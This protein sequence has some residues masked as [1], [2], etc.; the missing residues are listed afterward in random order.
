MRLLY[1]R[2]RPT[3]PNYCAALKTDDLTKSWAELVERPAVETGRAAPRL[4]VMASAYRE[5]Y[6]PLLQYLRR[7]A[8][9]YQDRTIAVTVP[10]IVERRW[11]NFFFRHRTTL[12]KGLLLLRG[13]PRIVI[14]TTPWYPRDALRSQD[15]LGSC[16]AVESGARHPPLQQAA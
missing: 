16:R 5:F 15:S 3:L 12:L 10:E 2:Q 7:V 14:I 9:E 13:G 6:G 8:E 1:R 4:V 11:Y